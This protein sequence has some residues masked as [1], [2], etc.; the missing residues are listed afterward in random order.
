MNRKGWHC[1][2]WQMIDANKIDEVFIGNTNLWKWMNN[3]CHGLSDCMQQRSL[4]FIYLVFY[5]HKSKRFRA[6]CLVLHMSS[7]AALSF[8][9]F[10]PI[11]FNK[12]SWDDHWT[13][14][15]I[16]ERTISMLPLILFN[17]TFIH[18]RTKGK[19]KASLDYL[20]LGTI[21]STISK[22]NIANIIQNI[23]Q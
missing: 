2:I 14:V 4:E 1:C 18:G 9:C 3:I 7:N 21:H 12:R 5:Y 16:S 13:R 10:N 8:I 20:F 6:M 22:W 11:L 23:L 15:V 19:Y 17:I